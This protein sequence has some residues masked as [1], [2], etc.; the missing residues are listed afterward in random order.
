[1]DGRVGQAEE[2]R[3]GC[4]VV[5]IVEGDREAEE[6]PVEPHGLGHVAHRDDRVEERFDAAGHRVLQ[7][8]A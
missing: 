8:V 6:V 7:C 2:R 1:M 4:R 3:D 5:I